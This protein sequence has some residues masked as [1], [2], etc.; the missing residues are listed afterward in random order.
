M[1]ICKVEHFPTCL[2]DMWTFIFFESLF[3]FCLYFLMGLLSLFLFVLRICVC[4]YLYRKRERKRPMTLK[5]QRSQKKTVVFNKCQC[6]LRYKNYIHTHMCICMRDI[7]GESSPT[8]IPR[9]LDL[10]VTYI[11]NVSF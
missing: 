9:S 5:F 8:S 3:I 2:L 1:V 11:Q 10:T 6:L 4:V 7:Y